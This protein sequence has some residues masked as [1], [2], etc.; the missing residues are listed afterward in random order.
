MG[1][2]ICITPE[3]ARAAVTILKA[4]VS[5]MEKKN[6]LIWSRFTED[7]VPVSLKQECKR[8]DEKL[9]LLAPVVAMLDA[10]TAS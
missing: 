7:R 3:S 2:S 8:R 6:A 5:D 4:E 10:I 1:G 9:A